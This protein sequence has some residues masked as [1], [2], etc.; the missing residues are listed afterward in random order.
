M[1]RRTQ[2]AAALI[3]MIAAALPA[4]AAQVEENPDAFTQMSDLLI[5]R[6]IGLV[7]FG[8]GSVTYVA[9][10]PF[11]LAGGNAMDAGES[12]VIEPA[13]EVF[14]RCLG[15]RRPGRKEKITE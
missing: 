6:P 10:L 11:S 9:T 5:A 15:C 13:K 14:V 3:L 1:S 2:V 12:L 8:L 4:Q 7:L